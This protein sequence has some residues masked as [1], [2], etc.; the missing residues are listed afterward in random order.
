MDIKNLLIILIGISILTLSSVVLA[1]A[2]PTL[3]SPS[4]GVTVSVTPTLSWQA[5]GGAIGYVPWVEGEWSVFTTETSITVPSG[6]LTGGT[7]YSWRVR[8]CSD[9]PCRTIHPWS[10]ARTF[11]TRGEAPLVVPTN[12]TPR[13]GATNVSL[14]PTLYWSSVSGAKAY[15]ANIYGEW[16]GI[17][18]STSITVPAGELSEGI[19]YSWRVRACSDV[20][21]REPPYNWSITWTFTTKKAEVEEEEQVPCAERGESCS[22]NSDCCRPQLYNYQ[23]Q[24]LCSSNNLCYDPSLDLSVNQICYHDSECKS[25]NC[26]NNKCAAVVKDTSNGNGDE[27]GSDYSGG[28]FKLKNPLEHDTFEGMLGGISK[29][30]FQIGMALAPLMLIIAGFMYVT[31]AGSPTRVQT[32]QRIALYT[33][34]G[35]AIILLASGLIAVLKSIIG[36]TG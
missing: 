2:A 33:V 1:L 18:R 28:I 6:E 24:M 16:S 15:V 23:R 4:D 7:T 29:F 13:N 22:R 26:T 27:G 25:G 5:V 3:I 17:T 10:A 20:E 32:A 34:I 11:T 14:T 21:C 19:T 35:L 30:L 12:P 8:S 31:S 9:S 36:Y